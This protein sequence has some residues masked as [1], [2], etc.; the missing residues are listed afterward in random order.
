MNNI[1]ESVDIGIKTHMQS[2]SGDLWELMTLRLT[3][4][5]PFSSSLISSLKGKKYFFLKFVF[6]SQF[7]VSRGE[8]V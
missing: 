5:L 7:T 4:S 2:F 3:A 6:C 1:S 8:G